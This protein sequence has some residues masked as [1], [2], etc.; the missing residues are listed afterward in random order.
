M[1]LSQCELDILLKADDELC[2]NGYT[3]QKCPRCGNEI[4]CEEKGNSYTIRCKTQNCIKT[5]FRGI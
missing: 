1:Q 3:K 2:K 4:I 5:D